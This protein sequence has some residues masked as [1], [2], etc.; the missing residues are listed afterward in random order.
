MWSNSLSTLNSS[1]PPLGHLQC[2]VTSAP[3]E[4]QCL[5]ASPASHA[6]PNP[7]FWTGL[8][9]SGDFC[10]LYLQFPPAFALT[11]LHPQSLLWL[12]LLHAA[13]QAEMDRNE[14][15]L[16]QANHFMPLPRIFIQHLFKGK[17][18]DGKKACWWPLCDHSN[19]TGRSG[20]ANQ[21]TAPPLTQAELLGGKL[22]IWATFGSSSHISILLKHFLQPC[23]VFFLG[24]AME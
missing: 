12:L 3:P 15:S 24:G 20:F 21:S 14:R 5:G 9:C 22:A 11:L 13:F 10:I 18:R 2:P 23:A 16:R 1:F 7:P 4:L 17:R 8:L 6:T 19:V